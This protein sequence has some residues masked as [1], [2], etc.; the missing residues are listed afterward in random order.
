MESQSLEVFKERQS[1]YRGG[2]WSQV[3]LDD[4]R[5][6]FQPNVFLDSVNLERLVKESTKARS[7]CLK[8]RVIMT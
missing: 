6:L 8:L 2:V 1:G 3:G 4:P 5:V 7:K